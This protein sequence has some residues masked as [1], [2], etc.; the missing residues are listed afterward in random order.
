MISISCNFK[1]A[2]E[3][4]LQACALWTM[5][6]VC[7]TIYNIALHLFLYKKESLKR[8]G[9]EALPLFPT[10]RVGKTGCTWHTLIHSYSL[11]LCAFSFS[12]KKKKKKKM[13]TEFLSINIC[14]SGMHTNNWL[15]II[16]TV[17]I[18]E[19]W[20]TNSDVMLNTQL[21]F[22]CCYLSLTFLLAH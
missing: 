15:C 5:G 14:S 6:C 7:Y 12:K 11:N 9:M 22:L 18:H 8:K 2:Y 13:Q 16:I 1:S 3:S 17:I 21:F 4:T 20:K 19:V 10:I